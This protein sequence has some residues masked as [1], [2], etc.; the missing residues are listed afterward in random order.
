SADEAGGLVGKSD[1]ARRKFINTMTGADW[2]DAGNYH[3]AIDVS[4]TGFKTAEE[5]IRLLVDEVKSRIAAA[6]K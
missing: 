4:K 1:R 6:K 3:L 5:M 2:S